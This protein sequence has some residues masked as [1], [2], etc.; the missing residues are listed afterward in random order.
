MTLLLPRIYRHPGV[1][2][3]EVHLLEY[4]TRNVPFAT[5]SFSGLSIHNS[6]INTLTP[7]CG[8]QVYYSK[9]VTV[10]KYVGLNEEFTYVTTF[11][12]KA[13]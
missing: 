2:T 6:K 8:N 13:T 1:C 9:I 11:S 4:M 5:G 10:V 3:Y 7:F 12:N